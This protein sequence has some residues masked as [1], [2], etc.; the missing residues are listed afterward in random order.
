MIVVLLEELREGRWDLSSLKIIQYAASP[1]P[2]ETLKRALKAFPSCGFLQQYG[3]TETTGFT[4][5]VDDHLKAI[6]E[7]PHLLY[8][9]GRPWAQTQVKIVTEAEGRLSGRNRR[10]CGKDSKNDAGYWRNPKKQPK[11]SGRM[12]VYGGHGK[13][14][15]GRLSLHRRQEKRH[16]CDGGENVYPT[17]VEDIL[18]KHPAVLEPQSSH[19]GSEMGWSP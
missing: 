14:R 8:S 13:A 7:K 6:G 5:S 4:L 2:A 17:E 18:F 15:R 19:P 10:N 12:A 3:T 11:P 1:I 9:C 16:D